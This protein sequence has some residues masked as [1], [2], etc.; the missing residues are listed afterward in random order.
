VLFR[1]INAWL[2]VHNKV[3]S[4]PQRAGDVA[5]NTANSRNKRIF[6]DRTGLLAA[7]NTRPFLVQSYL[8]DLGGGK[9]IPMKEIDAPITVKNRHWGGFRTAYQM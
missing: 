3:Y 5:W 7:R 9:I 6:D 4:Q 8:R 1:S 2:P